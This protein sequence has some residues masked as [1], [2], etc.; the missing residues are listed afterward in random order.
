M[1]SEKTSRKRAP[2]KT[3][4]QDRQVA[5]ALTLSALV[6][7]ICKTDRFIAAR[8]GLAVNTGLTLRNWIIGF[9]IHQYE[10]RGADRAEYGV[11][12]LD[13]LSEK[14]SKAGIRG[15]ASRTLRLYRQFYVAYP[16]IR[17]TLI[18]KSEVEP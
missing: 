17:Q 4:R 15:V 2:I 11:H 10:Q 14:L 16:Q 8:V 7:V 18:A 9:Y 6:D 5:P 13:V 12:L 3:S 1:K